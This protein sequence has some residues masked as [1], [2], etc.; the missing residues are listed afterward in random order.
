MMEATTVAVNMTEAEK[1][2]FEAYLA[3]KKVEEEKMAAKQMRTDYRAMV[4]DAIESLMPKLVEVSENL[5]EQKRKVFEEFSTI[6]E[7]KAELFKMEKGED[8]DNQSHSF[9]NSK[10][11]MRIVLGNYVTDGYMDTAEEGIQ[12]VQTFIQSLAS[13]DNSKAL[14]RMVMKLLAKDAKGT[15]KASR[16]IQLRKMAEESGN[17]EFIEGV[18]I[19]EEAYQPQVSRTFLKA[20]NKDLETGAWVQVPLGMTES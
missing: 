3:A 2:Q 13:D 15:L 6:L 14:V 7:L 8:L 1:A 17:A 5:A 19:I 9:T 18:S 10:G 4:D 16:I 11:N 12:K 20:Y